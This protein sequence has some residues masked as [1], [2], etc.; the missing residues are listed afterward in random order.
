M[1]FRAIQGVLTPRKTAIATQQLIQRRLPP[2]AA[3][4]AV[5]GTIIHRN[6]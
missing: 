5:T 1:K 3:R 4:N 6:E 2:Q